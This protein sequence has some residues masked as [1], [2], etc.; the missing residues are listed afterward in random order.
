MLNNAI[1]YE[2]GTINLTGGSAVAYSGFGGFQNRLIIGVSADTDARLRRTIEFSVT[3]PKI[4]PNS[5]NG[6]TQQKNRCVIKRPILLANGKFT[7]CSVSIDISYD[8]EMSQTEKQKLLDTAAQ[9][10]FNSDFIEFAK[11]GNLT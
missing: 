1:A 3:A 2:G 10:F 9:V 4:S 7:T 6:Y 8:V 11:N 5:P